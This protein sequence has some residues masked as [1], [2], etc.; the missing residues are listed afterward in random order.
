MTAAHP[1]V[2]NFLR[3]LALGPDTLRR[4]RV[5]VACSGGLDS[6]VLLHLVR[7]YTACQLGISHVNFGLRGK[8]SDGD[9][10]FIRSL[11]ERM[12][13]NPKP[14]RAD[15]PTLETDDTQDEHQHHSDSRNVK[16]HVLRVDLIALSEPGESMQMAARRIRYKYFEKILEEYRY[17]WLLVAHH[18]DDNLETALMNMGRKVLLPGTL[19]MPL[20]KGK[21]FRPL[22][23]ASR[24]EIH[25]YALAN[26]LSWR[27]DGSNAGDKYL[28]NR[29]RHHVVPALRDILGLDGA[30]YG[31][32]IRRVRSQ[33]LLLEMGYNAAFDRYFNHDGTEATVFVPNRI[34][35][36]GLDVVHL[37]QRY[38]G[39]REFPEA[40]LKRILDGTNEK[41]KIIGQA[42]VLV[43][44]GGVATIRDREAGD[45]PTPP[46]PARM[47]HALDAV[48]DL[49]EHRSVSLRLIARPEEL[50]APGVQYL[51]SRV[52]R[53]L[54]STQPLPPASGGIPLPL[55]LRARQN[56]DRF[57]PLGMRGTKKLQDF[58]VDR[59]VPRERRDGVPLLVNHQGEILAVI[60]YVVSHPARVRADDERVLE[61]RMVSE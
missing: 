48:V 45:A 39:G 22:L 42:K 14:E 15:S 6:T 38:V 35:Q 28:R 59:K 47:I 20:Q 56:G 41:G 43:L 10:A 24:A 13:S 8:A 23:Y 53:D 5:L 51:S 4:G 12:V 19:G 58:F 37:V 52:V 26:D 40:E 60:G 44:S 9:E 21:I 31:E 2:D 1:L 18:A 49:D 3:T 50:D 54:L 55:H 61:I 57:R 17:D 32:L 30:I 11:A 36:A 29:V 27:E 16:A 34:R 46:F 7:H 33:T 25:D